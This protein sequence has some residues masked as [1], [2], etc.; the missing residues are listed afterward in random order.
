MARHGIAA[1]PRV[2]ACDR[3]RGFAL[4]SWLD[5]APVGALSEADID[6]EAAFLGELNAL[7]GT[8][9]FPPERLASE[10]CLS[11]AEIVRQIEA[12]L[13]RLRALPRAQASL[14]AFLAGPFAA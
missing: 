13:I 5:G 7:R 4:L 9:E 8:A 10:A 1:V 3:E 14:H 2:L 11:A 6:A 12:R